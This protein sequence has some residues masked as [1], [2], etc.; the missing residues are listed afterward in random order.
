MLHMIATEKAGATV[1]SGKTLNARG[2]STQLF[3]NAISFTRRQRRD[4]QE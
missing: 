1:E 2:R 4:W 3:A